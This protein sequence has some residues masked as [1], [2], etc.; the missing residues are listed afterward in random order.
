MA[1]QLKSCWDHLGNTAKTF[2]TITAAA[3]V[4]SSGVYGV[5]EFFHRITLLEKALELNS[6]VNRSNMTEIPKGSPNGIKFSLWEAK[7]G[8]KWFYDKH[9]MIFYTP[10]E[11]EIDHTWSYVPEDGKH[12]NCGE[13][14]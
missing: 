7:N 14:E 8:M 1:N 5:L 13:R 6:Y 2:L 12:Y 4:L 11:N 10:N 3:S 9:D